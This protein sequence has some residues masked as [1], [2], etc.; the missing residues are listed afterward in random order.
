[1]A[2][3]SPR[4]R[5][6]LS[7]LMSSLGANL[8]PVPRWA[9]RVGLLQW[10]VGLDCVLIGAM[11]LV[12]PHQLLGAAPFAGSVRSLNVLGVVQFVAGLALIVAQIVGTRRRVAIPVHLLAGASFLA[13]SVRSFA[14]GAWTAGGVFGIVALG[15]MVVPFLEVP[16]RARGE[17]PDWTAPDLFAVTMGLA[18]VVGGSIA[19]VWPH[20]VLGPT[21]E[22]ANRLVPLIGVGFCAGGIAL[23]V[24]ELRRGSRAYLASGAHLALAA[25]FLGWLCLVVIPNRAWIG[26]V[27]YGGFGLVLAV[28]PWLRPRAGSWDTSSLRVRLAVLLAGAVAVPLIAAAGVVSGREEAMEVAETLTTQRSVAGSLSQDVNQ[29]LNPYRSVLIA[30][31]DRLAVEEGQMAHGADFLRI[32]ALTHSDALAFSLFGADGRLLASSSENADLATVTPDARQLEPSPQG[33]SVTPLITLAGRPVIVVAALVMGQDGRPL[34]RIQAVLEPSILGGLMTRVNLGTGSEVY[35]VDDVGRLISRQAVAAPLSDMSSM[36]PIS[37]FL[38]RAAFVDSVP[39]D[40]PDGTRLASFARVPGLEWGVVVERPEALV[41]AATRA[42]RDL[43]FILLVLWVAGAAALGVGVSS[44]LTAPLRSLARAADRVALGD[45]SSEVPRTAMREVSELTLS[46]NTMRERLTARTI[47]RER[48]EAQREE[49]SRQQAAYA[50]E[51]E[52]RNRELKQTEEDQA[53]LVAI[54]EATTDMVAMATADGRRIYMNRAGRRLLG[55][56]ED[57][58]LSATAMGD[59]RPA[60]AHT[61]LTNEALPKAIRDGVCVYETAYLGPDGREIP[62][63]SVLLVHRDAEGQVRYYSTIGRDITHLKNME[64]Q[65]MRAQ[66]LETAGRIAGQVAHDFNNLLAP[67]VGYPE[68]IKM[69]LPEGH[70]ARAYCDAMLEAAQQMA[71][72]SEDLLALGRRGHFNHE[73]TDLNRLV[74]QALGQMDAMPSTLIVNR[75]L[76]DDLLPVEGAPAQLARVLTNLIANARE[77]MSDVGTVSL[78]TEN[79]YL[80]QPVGRYGQVAVGEYVLFE[81]SD[82]GIGIAPEVR[83]RIFDAFFTTKQAGRRRGSGLGLSVVQSI[84]EDHSGYL[85]VTSEVGSGT[86][87]RVYLPISRVAV[88]SAPREGIVGGSERILIVDDDAGQ[89]GVAR[90]LLETLGYRVHAVS[91]GEEALAYF[92]NDDADLVVLDMVMPPGMDGAESYRRILDLRPRQR[93]LVVSGFAESDRVRLAQELGAGPYVRKPVTLEK[94]GLAVRAELDRDRVAV[95]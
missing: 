39:Y 52:A 25:M 33:T 41:L 30:L 94:L 90:D 38:R 86:T 49:L 36:A 73:P 70:P 43:A 34:G 83:D 29:Y 61:L 7:V 74:D 27:T 32:E 2:V 62:T 65:L 18:A 80:D 92:R 31:A 91:S 46:F 23:T 35:L 84:V 72:I 69:R 26:I 28:A 60:W 76:A 42:S 77:A 8:H 53:R 10:M 24:V 21:G 48:V 68:L 12:A 64:E 37:A 58:D 71:T 9:F 55:I 17:T 95:A 78:R 59:H 40:A 1:M 67:L 87:F 5:G 15:T 63:L 47:E 13:L 85:D 57:D 56:G 45:L 75:G 14:V 4:Q 51:I 88:A 93:A 22:A 50:S 66:R 82:T 19:V 16:P 81:V 3:E 20:Q 6:I 89:R 79:V 11:A 54:I 44:S